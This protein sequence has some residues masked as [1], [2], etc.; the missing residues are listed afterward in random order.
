MTTDP[1]NILLTGNG[2]KAKQRM[3]RVTAH[4]QDVLL[5][6]A[7]ALYPRHS[8]AELIERALEALIGNPQPILYFRL[9]DPHLQMQLAALLAGFEQ[10]LENKA[11]AIT[12]ARFNDANDQNAARKATQEIL[13][14]TDEIRSAIKEISEDASQVRKLV[15]S[16]SRLL[17]AASAIAARL[18]ESA[19]LRTKNAASLE[20]AGDLGKAKHQ[21]DLAAK[22]S[23][24][25]NTVEQIVRHLTSQK[26][27]SPS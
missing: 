6:N 2:G 11:K 20:S 10:Q 24:E 4:T 14:L 13:A 3:S 12:R 25:A 8:H 5:K 23:G 1:G 27:P 21:T 19:A 18:R 9:Q 17:P 26:T 15:D 22:L 7:A 16:L